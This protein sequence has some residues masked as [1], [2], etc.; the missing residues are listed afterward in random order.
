MNIEINGQALTGGALEPFLFTLYLQQLSLVETLVCSILSTEAIQPVKPFIDLLFEKLKKLLQLMGR[1][2]P[3]KESSMS[4]EMH[5]V[6]QQLV[7][8][9]F[10][11]RQAEVAVREIEYADVNLAAEWLFA[12]PE[13][14][15]TM[16]VE[17]QG[18]EL[19][20]MDK[21]EFQRQALISLNTMGKMFVFQLYELNTGQL[22]EFVLGLLTF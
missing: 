1:S 17:R 14:D 2:E 21:D 6:V 15:Q 16:E 19:S 3:R 7:D 10:S 9:G 4:Q 18:V 5:V 22:S 11:E 12:H 13:A 20:K 8:M